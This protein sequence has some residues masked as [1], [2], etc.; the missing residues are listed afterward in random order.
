LL[1]LEIENEEKL[2]TLNYLK[3][4]REKDKIEMEKDFK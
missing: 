4:L 3:E 1:E 2:K